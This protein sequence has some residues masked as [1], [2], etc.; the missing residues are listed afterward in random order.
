[1]FRSKVLL[2]PRGYKKKKGKG[3][4]Q[5]HKSYMIV[6]KSLWEGK[7]LRDTPWLKV[8]RPIW[9]QLNRKR[10]KLLLLWR[11][12]KLKFQP[13]LSHL[14]HGGWMR[15]LNQLFLGPCP[16]TSNF[17]FLCGSLSSQFAYLGDGTL[18]HPLPKAMDANQNLR[19]LIH[20]Q[21]CLSSVSP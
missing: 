11:E 9:T 18:P 12:Q 20:L 10:T 1:M 2:K 16:P 19:D 3:K 8:E 15:R 5:T 17:P 14:C 7:L 21:R 6:N 4:K 13:W